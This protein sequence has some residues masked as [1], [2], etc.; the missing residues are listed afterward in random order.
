MAKKPVKYS[1]NNYKLYLSYNF[2]NKDPIIDKLRTLVKD[3]G[4]TYKE[5]HEESGVTE[6][7][8]RN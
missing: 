1:P 3:S 4:H 2:R 8:L 6:G 7:T 5:I